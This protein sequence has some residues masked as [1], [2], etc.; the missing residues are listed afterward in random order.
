MKVLYTDLDSLLDT[1]L[2]VMATLDPGAAQSLVKQKTYWDREQDDW[3]RLTQGKITQEAF[4]AAWAVRGI[5]VLKSS[6]ASQLFLVLNQL[7]GDFH[8]IN[9]EGLTK[10]DLRLEVN[11][12]PYNLNSDEIETLTGV[13]KE[14]LFPELMVTFISRPLKE[15]TPTFWFQHYSGALI[16]DFPGWLKTHC[17]ELGRLKGR[18][19]NLIVPRLFEK[20]PDTLS[21]EEKKREFFTFK[22]W[23]LEHIDIDFI[24]PRYFSAVPPDV[25]S[26]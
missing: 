1:R 18:D 26:L 7:F 16:Y 19:F 3:E 14:L 6:V 5:E 12:H 13:L 23:L 4:K 15:L 2:G 21:Q 24:E 25:L 9:M 22:L 11:V 20:D 17:W 8:L 10:S